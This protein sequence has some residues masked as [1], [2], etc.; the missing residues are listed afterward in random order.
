MRFFSL[1]MAIVMTVMLSAVPTTAQAKHDY[2]ANVHP[3]TNY[4]HRCLGIGWSDGYHAS[5]GWEP[6]G[7]QYRCW[8]TPKHPMY[9]GQ[10][11]PTNW[12]RPAMYQVPPTAVWRAPA[13]R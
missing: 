13:R 7:E 12:S 10:Q 3:L 4:V 9:A 2:F 6:M 11:Y 5:G 8:H 1:I